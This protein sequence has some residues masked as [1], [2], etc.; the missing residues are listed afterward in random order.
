M[1]QISLVC[2]LTVKEGDDCGAHESSG[3]RRRHMDLMVERL[4][5]GN[6]ATYGSDAKRPQ[7][8]FRGSSSVL[9]PVWPSVEPR[10]LCHLLHGL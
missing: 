10:S 6:M 9:W 5:T 8:E 3:D 1:E 2:M 4:A 7:L